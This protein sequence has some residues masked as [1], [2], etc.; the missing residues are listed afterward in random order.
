MRNKIMMVGFA[1]LTGLPFAVVAK[2][3]DE[4]GKVRSN[5]FWNSPFMP[6]F[7]IEGAE[8]PLMEHL[9]AP[10]FVDSRSSANV[11]RLGVV[12]N[13]AETA[14]LDNPLIAKVKPIGLSL[15]LKF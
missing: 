13:P 2:G 14:E 7:G 1:L 4:G 9:S 6:H 11:W 8:H 15:K 12:S 5:S 10:V 3:F